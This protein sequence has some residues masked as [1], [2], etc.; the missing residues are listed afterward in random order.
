MQ[1]RRKAVTAVATLGMAVACL[2][3]GA[4]TAAAGT[5]GQQIKLFD[6]SSTVNSF[7]LSGPDQSGQWVSRCWN[8]QGMTTYASGWWW[9][10]TVQV[11]YYHGS[12][13]NSGYWASTSVEVPRHQDHSDWTQLYLHDQ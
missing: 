8:R 6:T 2:A 12:N 3:V 13:C 4:G 5:N 1:I 11:D 7:R 10:G 9:K